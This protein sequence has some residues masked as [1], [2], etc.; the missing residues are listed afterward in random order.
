MVDRVPPWC[1]F[2][3]GIPSVAL[4]LLMAEAD[5]SSSRSQTPIEG[6]TSFPLLGYF[7]VARVGLTKEL[8]KY[9]ERQGHKMEM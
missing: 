7:N 2:P 6:W 3:L 1:R 9:Q 8:A 5:L 4:L